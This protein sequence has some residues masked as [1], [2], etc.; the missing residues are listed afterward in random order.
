[1]IYQAATVAVAIAALSYHNLIIVLLAFVVVAAL[2]KVHEESQRPQIPEA[3]SSSS[4]PVFNAN[5][6]L[7]LLP[8]SHHSGG[9]GVPN[10][11]H[12]MAP[13][14]PMSPS[15]PIGHSFA[16]PSSAPVSPQSSQSH[17]NHQRRTS[18]T[19]V[20][21]SSGNGSI[22]SSRPTS[23]HHRGSQMPSGAIGTRMAPSVSTLD[24]AI[25]I[26]A[27][28]PTMRHANAMMNTGGICAINSGTG[29]A[30]LF[31]STDVNSNSSSSSTP[32]NM[33]INVNA[34]APS[35][36]STSTLDSSQQHQQQQQQHS[37]PLSS[38]MGSQS[39]S[40]M[41][42]SLFPRNGLTSTSAAL[43]AAA[44]ASTTPALH[45]YTSRH[46]HRRD[47]VK[48]KKASKP[49]FHSSAFLTSSSTPAPTVMAPTT[50]RI[51]PT[52]ATSVPLQASTG[53]L[54]AMASLSQSGSAKMWM[55]SSGVKHRLRRVLQGVRAPLL[56][57]ASDVG[58]RF[59]YFNCLHHFNQSSTKHITHS[60]V[61]KLCCFVL[62]DD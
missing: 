8:P 35:S 44:S 43:T 48:K 34:T 7:L 42:S 6:P 36:T 61:L 40:T 9:A 2:Q 11:G 1:M 50:P 18:I 37:S 57:I 22:A 54:A 21:G 39:S 62:C 56:K 38:P 51:L 27:P 47:E 15:I 60:F 24:A 29:N 58:R 12:M 41:F 28:P 49:V 13:H 3:S 17:V 26:L 30:G 59:F 10:G 20:A 19:G 55:V 5:T 32:S 52:S 14:S 25:N 31:A 45:S 46:A 33:S 53:A 4:A 16:I 23:A